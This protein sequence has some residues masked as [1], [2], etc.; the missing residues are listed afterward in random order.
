MKENIHE[1][2][3]RWFITM[4]KLV[5]FLN[6]YMLIEKLEIGVVNQ[7]QKQV[8]FFSFFFLTDDF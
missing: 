6:I 1:I 2:N 7:S 4:I 3:N 5:F 8:F